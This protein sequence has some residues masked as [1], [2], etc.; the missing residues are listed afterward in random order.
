MAKRKKKGKIRFRQSA[1]IAKAN[2]AANIGHAPLLNNSARIR[3][4]IKHKT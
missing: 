1:R 4:T 2:N 3:L